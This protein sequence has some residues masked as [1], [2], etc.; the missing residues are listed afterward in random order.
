[1]ELYELSFLKIDFSFFC[2][3]TLEKAGKPEK[4][5]LIY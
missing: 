5:S 2:A 4:K 3:E 1:V